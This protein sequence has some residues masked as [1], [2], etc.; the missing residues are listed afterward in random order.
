[1][2]TI[3]CPYC[4][5]IVDISEDLCDYSWEENTARQKFRCPD[6]AKPLEIE[7]KG[8]VDDVICLT[9]APMSDYEAQEQYGDDMRDI[10]LDSKAGWE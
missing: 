3:I 6:C 10:Y 9:E 2:M 5:L 8:Y 1:M 4:S 7:V